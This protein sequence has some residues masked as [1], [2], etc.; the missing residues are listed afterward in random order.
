MKLGGIL[1]IVPEDDRNFTQI[2]NLAT[3]KQKV[4]ESKRNI[5]I[6]PF[7]SV[8][9]LIVTAIVIAKFFSAPVPPPPSLTG[10]TIFA[11]IYFIAQ[12]SE[13]V[14][15]LFSDVSVKGSS[16]RLGEYT[17]HISYIDMVIKNTIDKNTR[18]LLELDHPSIHDMRQLIYY[19]ELQSYY[20]KRNREIILWAVPS[21][22]AVIFTS[23]TLGLFGI[24]GITYIPHVWDSLFSGM[25]IGGGT[26]P[27]HDLISYIQS[28]P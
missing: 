4:K 18:T 10:I 16:P 13:R 5:I 17:R 26:K 14:T 25:I 12:L 24:I 9:I 6:I 22:F 28:K 8:I 1:K 3:L 7:A 2:D 27:L 11:V 20:D 21:L 15:E 19:N 23:L